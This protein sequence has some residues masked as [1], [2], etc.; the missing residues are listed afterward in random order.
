[1]SKKSVAARAAPA[2][3]AACRQAV[4]DQIERSEIRVVSKIA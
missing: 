4:A 3:I 1:V 2:A